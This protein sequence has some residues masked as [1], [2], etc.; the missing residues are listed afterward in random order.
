MTK[1]FV[2]TT[3]VVDYIFKRGSPLFDQAKRALE[4]Y[5]TNE[6]PTYALK[7]LCAGVLQNYI[8]FHNK[9]V[10]TGSFAAA[11]GAL[12]SLRAHALACCMSPHIAT[13]LFSH[14][15]PG[16]YGSAS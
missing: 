1:S 2:D 7:E 11:V 12:S 9:L 3:I 14:R 5:D 13:L 8:W 16:R 4:N 15:I 10:T 6:V